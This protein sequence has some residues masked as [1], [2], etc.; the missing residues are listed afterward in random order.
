MKVSEAIEYLSKLNPN[1]EIIIDWWDRSFTM[2]WDEDDNELEVPVD[3]WEF[4]VKQ[5][6]ERE[7]LTNMLNETIT[8]QIHNQYE[9]TNQ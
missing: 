4:V 5:V 6:G 2:I 1:E 3:D 9:R 7:D 8:E